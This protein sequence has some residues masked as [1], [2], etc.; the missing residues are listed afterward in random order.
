MYIYIYICIYIYLHEKTTISFKR[1]GM[2]TPL[3]F[4]ALKVKL[5]VRKHNSQQTPATVVFLI[6]G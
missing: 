4:K 6:G 3:L 2:C 1:F 5:F